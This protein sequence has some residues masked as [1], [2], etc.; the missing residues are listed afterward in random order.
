[1]RAVLL[2]V[3]AVAAPALANPLP[4]PDEYEED[5]DGNRKIPD[6]GPGEPLSTAPCAGDCM[7]APGWL[8]LDGT[9]GMVVRHGV[10]V[11]RAHGSWVTY[12]G[13]VVHP[14]IVWRTQPA[15]AAAAG[16]A[17]DMAAVLAPDA[18][19]LDHGRAP[20]SERD[21]MTA[22]YLVF[23]WHGVDRGAL[24]ATSQTDVPL[25]L[26]VPIASARFLVVAEP[27]D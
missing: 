13:K 6:T 26:H 20:A 19:H 27:I 16:S 12:A 5:R 1:M 24:V 3:L 9:P 23:T 15:S 17:R 25:N 22:T 21:A 18:A 4:T 7:R 2:A 11:Y 10:P 14:V 8:A